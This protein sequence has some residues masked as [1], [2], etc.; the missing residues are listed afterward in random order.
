VFDIADTA[1]FNFAKGP[2]L[3]QMMGATAYRLHGEFV[4]AR[5]QSGFLLGWSIGGLVFGVLADRWG[6]S[7]TLLLTVFL[8][9]SFTGLTALCRNPEQVFFARFVTA[10]GIGGEWAAGAALVA[11]A[12]SDEIRPLAASV[13]QTAAAFGPAFAALASFV[14]AKEPWQWLF[15]VGVS[16]AAFCVLARLRV[17]QFEPNLLPHPGL[18]MFRE[19]GF[20]RTSIA[21]MVVGAA[22]IAGAGTAT[23]WQPNLVRAASIG[24]SQPEI[25]SRTGLVGM[26][27]HI[28]T[29]GGVF[30]AP[31]LCRTIGRRTTIALF[32]ALAPAAV[33]LAVGGGAAYER[34]LLFLP[35]VNLFAIGVSAAFVLYFPELFPRSVRATGA[36]LAYNVGRLLAIPIPLF[37]AWAIGR[38]GNSA[39]AGVILS[40]SVYVLG[41]VALPFLPETRGQPLT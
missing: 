23:Y 35:L 2:M 5:I 22:G 9:C 19:P 15:L 30:L 40:G 34:L 29:L 28:G 39:A 24:L 12:F 1:L 6:R 18:D 3:I 14:L 38:F 32:F 26:V 33:V 25:I 4:E 17:F 11:E 20:V 13:L 41:L 10:L 16:P 36:G 31:W 8:Y 37:T 21:A 27:S 7:R